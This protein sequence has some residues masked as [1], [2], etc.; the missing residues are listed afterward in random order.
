[1]SDIIEKLKKANLLGRGGANF[2][3][4]AKWEAV[5]KA[6]PPAGG[7]KYVV[8][9]ASEGEPGAFK[10]EFILS[11]YPEEILSGIKIA[12]DEIGAKSTYIY[13]NKKYYLKFKNKIEKL[14]KKVNLELAVFKKPNGYICGEET[15]MLNVIEGKFEQ[16]RLKPPYPT[17][18]GLFNCPTIINNVETFYYV[19][20]IAKGEYKNTRFYSISGDIKNKGVFEMPENLTVRQI[21]EKTNNYPKKDSFIQVGGGACGEIRLV[22][23]LDNPIC[24]T[25]VL[26]VFDKKKTNP[27]NLMMQWAE[28][29]F[30]GNCD[31]CVPCRE[32]I[33]RIRE[34]VDN[35]KIE[36]EKLSEIFLA[37]EETSFCPLGRMAVTPFKTLL[38]KIIKQ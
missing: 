26:I 20:K 11:T 24:G 5:K 33:Y 3:T 23:E 17:E 14:A 27:M 37:M 35:K 32:G 36:K 25:G 10:D 13:L 34:M 4:G 18:Y 16:P 28:F 29:F 9:N 31:K 19:S 30:V 21:L 15:T 12:A 7:T 22:S 38:D 2:P 6:N 8:C 1:M